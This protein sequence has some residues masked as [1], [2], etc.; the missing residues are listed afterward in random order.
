MNW[1]LKLFSDSLKSCTA[2]FEPILPNLQEHITKLAA[3]LSYKISH[4]ET[5]LVLKLLSNHSLSRLK[6]Q[7]DSEVKERN[8]WKEKKV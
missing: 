3:E 2:Q 5:R 4:E 7:V 1:N 6:D 8:E